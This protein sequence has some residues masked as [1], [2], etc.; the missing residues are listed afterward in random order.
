MTLPTRVGRYEVRA[1]LWH[2]GMSAVYLAHDPALDRLVALKLLFVD[3][4]EIRDRAR[5]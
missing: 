2:G 4:A 5:S 1:R 3:D